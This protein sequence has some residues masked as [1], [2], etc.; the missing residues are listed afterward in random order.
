[1]CVLAMLRFSLRFAI[2]LFYFNQGI[3]DI[4]SE[5]QDGGECLSESCQEHDEGPCFDSGQAKLYRWDPVKV[6]STNAT[7]NTVSVCAL[8]N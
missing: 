2:L 7:L 6:G 8:C 5:N 1:M 4:C 3:S